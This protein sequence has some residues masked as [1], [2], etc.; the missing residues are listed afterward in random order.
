MLVDSHCHLDPE[1][2][3]EDLDE[4]IRRAHDNGIHKLMTISTKLSTFPGVLKVAETYDD[5]VCTVGVHPH[6]VEA[7]AE[8]SKER[9]LE[10]TQHPKVVGIG[11]TGL[12]YYYEHSPR[13]LQ[14]K[15]FD[16]HIQANLDSGLPLIVHCRDAMDDTVDCL[17]EMGGGNATGVIHCFSGT[18]GFARKVLDLGF[19]ISLSGVLTFKNAEEI[20]EVAKFAPM[21]RLLVETDSPFLAPVPHRGKRN[22]PAFTLHTAE[23]LADIRGMNV[24][25]IAKATTKNFERLFNKS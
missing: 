6:D 15:A 19:Y 13:D 24:T 5:V 8:L 3:Q 9:L 21:D 2:F 12:D 4:V 23:C 1:Y 16:T 17:R 25:D 14:K 7:E 10:L 22:E 18:M 11:E 20:R